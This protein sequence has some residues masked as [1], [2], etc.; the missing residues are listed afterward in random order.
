MKN[1]QE[2]LLKCDGKGKLKLGDEEIDV[3]VTSVKSKTKQLDGYIDCFENRHDGKTL[4]VTKIECDV[5]GS[6][7]SSLQ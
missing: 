7:F 2:I 3:Y 5:Y 4:M 6:E 1:I